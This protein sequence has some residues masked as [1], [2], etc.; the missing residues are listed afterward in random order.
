[1]QYKENPLIFIP[2]YNEREN[3]ELLHSQIHALGLDIDI[4]FIDDNSPD[5]TGEL[6]EALARKH[7]NV[8]VVHRSGKLGVGSAHY[9]GIQWAY[10]QRYRRIVT[11][12]CD[13]AHPPHYIKNILAV[14]SDVVV[15]SRYKHQ[16]SLAG[17]HL[18]RKILTRTGHFLT[19]TLLGM[20]FD[21]TGGFRSYRLD[22]IPSHLFRLVNSKGYSFFFESL[23]IIHSNGFS[24]SEIA[25]VLP[26]RT[27]GHSKMTTAEIR[28]SLRLLLSIYTNKLFY[29]GRFFLRNSAG[30]DKN[31]NFIN[32]QEWEEYWK[33]HRNFRGL[34]YG[35]IAAFYRKFIIRKTLNHFVD[36]YFSQGSSVLHAGCGS[37]QVDVD[38]SNRVSI[39]GLDISLNA[40]ERYRKLNLMAKTLHGSLF[41]IPLGD[42]SVD[43]VYN[44]GV[45][46][47]F[48]EDE[49]RIIMREFRR[50]IKPKGRLIVFWPPEYGVTVIFLGFLK[51]C[52]TN[53]FCKTR[54]KIHPEEITLVRSRQHAVSFFDGAGFNVLEYYFGIRDFFTHSVIVSEKPALPWIPPGSVVYSVGLSETKTPYSSGGTDPMAKGRGPFA[55]Q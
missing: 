37:G 48:T 11:M 5:G 10:A 34:V 8:Y 18:Y 4:L 42:A 14:D 39:T 41:D 54:V 23:F 33:P 19:K 7:D 15:G 43:G 29:P 24:I 46:E 45:M 16:E 1:V 13:F 53:I 30:A 40:L 32:A 35:W 51:W 31:E 17:W 9:S 38:I 49:I 2:T 50:V 20:P 47:H 25:I 22:K 36:R 21:A 6:L 27:Y 3:V 52:L 28:Q 12:D 44:L 55:S 26:P